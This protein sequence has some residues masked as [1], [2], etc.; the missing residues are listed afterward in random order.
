MVEP[1]NNWRRVLAMRSHTSPTVPSSISLS[2]KLVVL[3]FVLLVAV[4]LSATAQQG[5]ILVL[6]GKQ[7]FI[8]TNPLEP[9]LKQNPD[10]LPKS[11]VV[12][13]SLWRGYEPLGKSRTSVSSSRMW[14]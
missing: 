6:N 11:D 13:S 14:V 9:F 8:E 2:L 3:I 5:D 10:K 4:E 7:Y 1:A 12:S